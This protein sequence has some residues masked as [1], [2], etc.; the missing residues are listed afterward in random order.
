MSIVLLILKI[1]GIIL[2]VLLGLVILVFLSLMLVPVRYQARGRIEEEIDIS[3]GVS[4]FLHLIS[5]QIAFGSGGQEQTLR[6]L[7][8]PLRL[9]RKSVV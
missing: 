8:I 5:L 3:V 2:L 9:D 6:I 7:G 1:L 4:W